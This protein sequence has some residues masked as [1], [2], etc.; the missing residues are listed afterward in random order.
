LKAKILDMGVYTDPISGT[1]QGGIIS[2]TLANFTL[3][4]LEEAVKKS[5]YPLTKSTEQ[6]MQIKLKDGSFRRI[7]LATELIRY[8]DDFVVI[9]RSKNLLD[10]YVGPT[11]HGFLKERGL[12]LS[13]EKT[14]QYRLDQ[15]RAQLDF[16]GYTFKYNAK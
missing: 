14:K 9:T 1:P 16:L 7:S 6:R 13:P 3:N 15:P 4:G 5:L 8:A 2:P 11:I 10:K 12:R